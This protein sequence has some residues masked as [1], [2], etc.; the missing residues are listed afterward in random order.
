MAEEGYGEYL[1]VLES[2][3]VSPNVQ[4]ATSNS[5][6]TPQSGTAGCEAT[7][8]IAYLAGGCFWGMQDILRK[9]PGV[10]ETEVG[11]LGGT[12]SNPTYNDVKTGKTGH[13]ET[14]KVLF[15]PEKL[16]FEKLLE[17]WFFRMHDPTTIN[18][19]GND[20]GTQYRS[21]IFYTSATQQKT[22]LDVIERIDASHRWNAPIVTEVV[23]AGEFTPA[24]EYHQ[25][26]L[27]KHPGGYTCHYLR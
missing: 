9:I 26:Y 25:D 24:E 2:G 16:S 17:D 11:Y 8:E 12:T 20:N 13:A 22:A 23:L 6:T 3:S 18:R 5:C 1:T 4:T 7:V 19:Q 14:V 27:V 15:L 10:I 21:A